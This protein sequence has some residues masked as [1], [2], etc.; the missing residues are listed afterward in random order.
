MLVDGGTPAYRDMSDGVSNG[1]DVEELK[2][3]LKAL[4]FD[5]DHQITVPDVRRGDHRGGR[6]LAGVAGPDP[7]RNGD[8]GQIVVLPGSQRI[9]QVD[10]ALGSTGGASSGSAASGTATPTSGLPHRRNNVIRNYT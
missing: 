4:G 3:N 9:T 7:D 2:L 5:P 1:L 6:S 10:T 8:P